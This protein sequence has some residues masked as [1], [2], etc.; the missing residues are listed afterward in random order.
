[1]WGRATLM[2][3]DLNCL[4]AQSVQVSLG[5]VVGAARR[6]DMRIIIT[7]YARPTATVLNRLG[8]Q[9]ESVVLTSHFSLE[10]TLAMVCILGGDP[11]VWGRIAHAVGGSGHPQLTHAFIAGMAAKGWPEN[12]IREIIG[13]G[14]TN[15]DLED[16]HSAARTNLINSLP[17]PAR[18][19]LYRLCI[20]TAPFK[21]SLAVAIGELQP[22][23]ERASEYFDEL[24]D[25]W[26][27]TPMADRY[28][29]SP[30]VRGLGQKMLTTDQQRQVHDKIATDM[31]SR[32]H[33]DA[34]DID[35]ILVHGPSG[36]VA[37][38]SIQA[39]PCH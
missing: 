7:S 33:I 12:Q 26:L 4:A 19:L 25:R 8:A 15:A 18:E 14:F 5:E 3:D 6:R 30:L 39:Y 38:E 22:R 28:R 29:T 10:E 37:A 34:A 17:E 31:T 35:T 16:E 1:M 24:V 20:T 11:K 36:R 9:V 2:L 21:R 27:E 13:Q 32:N 23:I